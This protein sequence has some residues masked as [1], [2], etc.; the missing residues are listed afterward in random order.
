METH[1]HHIS[2]FFADRQGAE[3][4]RAALVAR[5]LPAQRISIFDAN[6]RPNELAPLAESNKTLT[7]IVTAGAIGTVVGTGIGGLAEIALVASSVTLFV[8]S[9]LI[10]PLVMMGWGASVGAMIGAA[11]GSA[12]KTAPKFGPLSDLVSDAIASGQIVLVVETHTAEE[13]EVARA[14]VH[15]AVGAYQEV[16]AS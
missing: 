9:P 11:A 10:A 16:K 13:T 4:V 14:V 5:Q 7:N 6:S 1:R 8:A 2:G 15:D 12:A 3:T